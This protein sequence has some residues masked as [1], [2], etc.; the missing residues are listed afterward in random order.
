MVSF[1]GGWSKA[2]SAKG[3]H[4][5]REE[6]TKDTGGFRFAPSTLQNYETKSPPVGAGFQLAAFPAEAY[7]MPAALRRL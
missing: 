2:Q 5:G 6:G 4:E 7:S 1:Y 3:K